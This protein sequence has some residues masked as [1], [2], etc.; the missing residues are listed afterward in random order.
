MFYVSW[1]H[2]GSVG[3]KSKK[4]VVSYNCILI[5]WKV[6]LK[7][8]LT[9]RGEGTYHNQ[10]AVFIRAGAGMMHYRK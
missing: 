9:L 4:K 5:R 1:L 10:T 6:A 7:P 3:A 2:L 8:K